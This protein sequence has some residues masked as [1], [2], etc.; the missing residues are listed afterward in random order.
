[1]VCCISVGK[2]DK[3]FFAVLIGCVSCFLNKFLNQYKSKL[4]ENAII[5]NIFLSGSKLL[6]IIPYLITRK[7]YKNK[8]QNESLMKT[9]NAEEE[10][11]NETKKIKQTKWRYL[12]LS[13]I[14]FLANQVTDISSIKIRSN[15]SNSNIIFTS[16]FYYLFFKNKLYIHHYLSGG[17]III[18]GITIDLILG[19]LQYDFKENTGLFFLRIFREALYSLSSNID[20]YVM[21]KKYISPSVLLFSNGVFNV[22]ILGIFSIFDHFFIHINKYKEYFGQFSAIELPYK[23]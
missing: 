1:M 9:D 16:L 21:E 14:A 23:A 20:K 6:G 19:N 2:F 11:S 4:S 3:Y 15:T 12:F 8:P 5:Q 18:L 17:L 22:T 7:L 13:A 10:K